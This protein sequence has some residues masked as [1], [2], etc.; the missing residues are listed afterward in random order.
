M[1]ISLLG[2]LADSEPLLALAAR[3]PAGFPSPAMDFAE[4]RVSLDA[5]MGLRAPHCFVARA[6]GDSM[7]GIGIH[8]GDLLIIDRSR[9]AEPG[10]VVVAAINGE[11]LVKIL[12]RVEGS[13]CLLSANARYGVIQL[14]ESD[15]LDVWGVVRWSVRHHGR[16]A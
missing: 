2:P 14:S 7:T 6:Q 4:E 12:A 8:D 10:E 3:I 13:L 15:Q 16:Y 5:L 1:V 9:Q 11:P